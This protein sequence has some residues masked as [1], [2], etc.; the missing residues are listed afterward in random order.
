MFLG[1]QNNKIVL[2]ANTKEKLENAPCIAFDKIVETDK[3]YFLHNGEYVMEIPGPTTAEKVQ[4]LEQA[5]G[6]TRAVR[7]LVLADGSGASDYVRAKAQEIET[8]ANP[9]RGVPEVSAPAGPKKE[10]GL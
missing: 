6:L 1:Y 2:V 5:T 3:N 8:L 9:L 4:V 10:E 7:E